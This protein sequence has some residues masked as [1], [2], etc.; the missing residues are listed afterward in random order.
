MENT[1]YSLDEDEIRKQGLTAE[2]LKEEINSMNEAIA[3]G[4]TKELKFNDSKSFDNTDYEF[5]AALD[6]GEH[7]GK[8]FLD[9][10]D[11]I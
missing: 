11:N 1:H 8:E 5:I 2:D 7:L 3:S 4:K 6:R 10:Y 9:Y